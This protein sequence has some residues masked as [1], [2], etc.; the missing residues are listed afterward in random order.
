M[1]RVLFQ[2]E[3]DWEAA[4]AEFIRGIE[5][6]PNNANGLAMY[7][8]F[9]VLIHKDCEGGL[10]LLDSARDLD[11]F[12]PAMHFDLGVYNL[13]CRHWE[14]SIRHLERTIELIPD[15]Y[16]P[17]MIIAWNYLLA[18]S[19]EA[20]V[21]QCDSVIKEAD[22]G[23]DFRLLGSCAWVYL[24]SGQAEQATILIEKLRNPPPE[25]RIDPVTNSY[26]CLVLGDKDCALDYLEQALQQRSSEMIFLRTMPVFD[27]IRDEPRFQAVM[28]QMNFPG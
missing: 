19:K 26:T 1:A 23:F 6:D 24:E 22:S 5:L 9:R 11:P 28:K 4:E 18:G 21:Q 10:A 20:A 25:I 14:E 15:F 27:P 13:H 12:N 7:G 3:W 8:Y 2:F 17:K 16:W